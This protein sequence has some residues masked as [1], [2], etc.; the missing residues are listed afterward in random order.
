MH[1]LEEERLACLA[2]C[3]VL[4]T[5]PEPLYDELT[6][7]AAR[8]CGTP[9][10]AIN[11]VDRERHFVKSAYGPVNRGDVPRGR[12]LCAHAILE[13]SAMMLADASLDGRFHDNPVVSK[14][15]GLRF[16]HAVALN[17]PEGLPLGTL[18]VG[19]FRRRRLSADACHQ[20][21]SLARIAAAA[22]TSRREAEQQRRSQL[23]EADS[24]LQL[25][26]DATGHGIWDWDGSSGTVYLSPHWRKLLGYQP[27][28]ERCRLEDWLELV[29]PEDLD[30]I[31]ESVMRHIEI[32]D[33][34]I[35]T[36]EYRMRGEDGAYRRIRDKAWVL[37]RD[38]DGAPRRIVGS[39]SMISDE[40][41]AEAVATQS[42][43]TEPVH[44]DPSKAELAHN[45]A[46]LELFAS[47]LSHDLRS[48]VRACS[49]YAAILAESEPG[50][51]AQGRAMLDTMRKK[52]AH[53]GAMVEAM[54]DY[55]RDGQQ[56]LHPRTVDL[57]EVFRSAWLD[58]IGLA[59][60]NAPE[61]II[62]AMP[63]CHHDDRL[64]HQVAANL[65]GNALK[66]SGCNSQPRIE[67]TGESSA[68]RVHV[69]VRDNGIGFDP[70]QGHRLFQPFQRLTADFPGTGLGL[71]SVRRAIERLGGRVWAEG[72]PGA[73]AAF[74]FELPC[75]QGGEATLVQREVTGP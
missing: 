47:T 50:L 57:G 30:N 71:A 14:D 70:A 28:D 11:L 35:H 58:L 72:R 32:C 10:A 2:A 53:I 23:A 68:A 33:H 36:A 45:L 22:L 42:Y 34:S 31:P 7:L 54:L 41:G 5:P 64:L 9:I 51:S 1:P 21:A 24:R 13:D 19:D 61:L 29:H 17:S 48:P 15:G 27:F 59:T 20:L 43:G 39:Y 52:T 75:A 16:Y 46:E 66:Y 63:E 18:N 62:G 40:T 65:L 3:Q 74:H 8:L 67:V 69:C 38:L 73:G 12:S 44:A 4:D 56:P 37:K 25:V 55:L 60:E 26:L 49:A 6:Q